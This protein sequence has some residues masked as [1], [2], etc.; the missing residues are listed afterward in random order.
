MKEY[1]QNNALI[2]IKKDTYTMTNIEISISSCVV[3]HLLVQ[4]ECYIKHVA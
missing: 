2:V 1:L 3:G 4:A